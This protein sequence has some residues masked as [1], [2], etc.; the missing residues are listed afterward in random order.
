MKV[1]GADYAGTC[2]Q[3]ECSRDDVVVALPESAETK[4]RAP[5]VNGSC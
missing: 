4:G 2:A 1:L 5:K 3:R